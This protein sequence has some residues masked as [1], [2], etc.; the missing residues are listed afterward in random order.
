MT[1]AISAAMRDSAWLYP[2]VEIV[3]ILGF[4]LLVGSVLM[5]DLRVLGLSRGI[6]VR[7]LARHLLPW[8]F[9]SLVL[10]VPSGLVMFA[11]FAEDLIS[12][13]VFTI[14]MGLVFA[15]A[16]NTAIFHTGPYRSVA[17]WDTGATAPVGARL[18]VALSIVLWIGVIACGRLLAPLDH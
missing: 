5:F 16:I 18:S 9:A 1:D 6:S 12:S 17:H 7:A 3:H 11:A 15:A 14:K 4:T 2:S 13:R 10:V 8:S